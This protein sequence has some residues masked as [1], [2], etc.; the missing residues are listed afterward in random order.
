MDLLTVLPI[1]AAFITFTSG[2]LSQCFTTSVVI[3]GKNMKQLTP[4]GWLLVGLAVA[5]LVTAVSSALISVNMKNN[6]RLL[7]AAKEAQRQALESQEERWRSDMSSL[8]QIAKDDIE[9][10]LGNTIAG[11]QDSQERFNRTQAEIVSSKQSVLESN[12]HHTNEIIVS[13]QPLTSLAFQFGFDSASPELWQAIDEGAK[14]ID[15]NNSSTQDGMPRVPYEA[16]EYKAAVL[17]LMSYV[18]R[19]ANRGYTEDE[20]QSRQTNDNVVVLISLDESQN[21]IL[22]FGEIDRAVEWSNN[23]GN[24]AISAGFLGNNGFA[25]GN[26]TPALVSHLAKSPRRGMSRYAVHWNLDPTTLAKS[27]DRRNPDVPSTAKLPRILQVAIL[28]STTM[29]PFPLNNFAVPSATNLWTP[30]GVGREKVA[31]GQDLKNAIFA[32]KVNGFR[33]IN[34]VLKRMFKVDLMDE[35]DDEFDT[36]C[37]LLEFEAT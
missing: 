16:M 14:E 34:Y 28:H 13:G 24:R 2:T 36:S 21:A 8:L 18:A 17:P 12:L 32:I 37:T 35:Y 25:V 27:I 9:K 29:L 22:S 4:V 19:I 15:E 7:A 3:N 30:V 33:Q 10:N 26:S 23:E 1:V 6:D 5:S 31:F 20:D 11:F